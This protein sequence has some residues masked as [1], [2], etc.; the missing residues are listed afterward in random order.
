[1]VLKSSLSNKKY[2][3]GFGIFILFLFLMVFLTPKPATAP[4]ERLTPVTT[5]PDAHG[6]AV[7]VDDSNKIY[8]ASHNGLYVLKD[9]QGLSV[10]GDNRDDYM[11]FSPHP[12]DRNIFFTSG[13]SSAG[14]NLGFQKTMDGGRSWQ[15]VSDGLNG[16]VDFHAMAVDR[17]DPNM[18]YGFYRGRLQF[19]GDGGRTWEYRDEAPA[20][21]I[22]L[23]PGSSEKGVIMAA[24]PSGIKWSRDT[25]KTWQDYAFSGEVVAAIAVHPSDPAALIAYRLKGGLTK[26]Q[27]GGKNWQSISLDSNEAVFYLAYAP[28]APDTIYALTRSLR[29]LKTTDA[30]M[31]WSQVKL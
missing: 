7:A 29:L 21:I 23:A 17:Q 31:S 24:T 8:I 16:P 18:I 14:G 2:I 3:L 30:G 4:T 9:G 13:H 25:G 5:L 11:G 1:M 6:L 12:T 19:S 10:I 27:D 26:T 20:Q 15:K 22:Q 28:Q